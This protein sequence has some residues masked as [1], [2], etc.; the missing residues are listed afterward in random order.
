[1]SDTDRTDATSYASKNERK[2]NETYENLHM[3][4]FLR[5]MQYGMEVKREHNEK[6]CCDS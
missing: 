5:S 6:M 2:K 1:M 3:A 4:N